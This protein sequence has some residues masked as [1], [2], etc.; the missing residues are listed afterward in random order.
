MTERRIEVFLIRHSYHLLSIK[1]YC[2]PLV[3]DY[4]GETEAIHHIC[5]SVAVMNQALQWRQE[6]KA[7]SPPRL[8]WLN[9][10]CRRRSWDRE[11]RFLARSVIRESKIQVRIRDKSYCY[12]SVVIM[13]PDT[14]SPVDVRIHWYHQLSY[15]FFQA[16]DIRLERETGWSFTILPP[17][18]QWSKSF[19]L[20][21][22]SVS[23][24]LQT[25]TGLN[26][27]FIYPCNWKAQEF[28]RSS[29]DAKRTELL[30]ISLYF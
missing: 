22:D 5:E 4:L 25:Q 24:N 20:Y 6:S 23:E 2:L 21:Q 29:V 30:F 13:S 12:L 10:C 15:F 18:G 26:K 19:L 28:C 14:C 7:V 27:E 1:M 16:E 3:L 17:P 11:S 9:H 8:G